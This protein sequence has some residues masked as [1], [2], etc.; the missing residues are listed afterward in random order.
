M[1]YYRGYSHPKILQNRFGWW[2]WKKFQCPKENHLW[3]EVWTPEEHYFSCDACG[4][5]VLIGESR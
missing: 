1:T 5:E 3:D 4:K 2:L